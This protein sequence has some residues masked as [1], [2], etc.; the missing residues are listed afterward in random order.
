MARFY[1]SAGMTLDWAGDKIGY[2]RSSMSNI[3]SGARPAS[4]PMMQAV[5][6]ATGWDLSDQV[7]HLEGYGSR[8]RLVMESLFV[9]EE[10]P[11]GRHSVQCPHCGVFNTAAQSRYDVSVWFVEMECWNCEKPLEFAN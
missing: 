9:A 7:N 1:S 6:D 8:L 4:M 3:F 11:L 2:A 10:L 5:Q